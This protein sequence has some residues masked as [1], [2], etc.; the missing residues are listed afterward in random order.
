MPGQNGVH[1]EG[2]MQVFLIKKLGFEGWK[3]LQSVHESVK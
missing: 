1:Y 2:M 3:Q